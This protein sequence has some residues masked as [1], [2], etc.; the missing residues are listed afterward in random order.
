MVLIWPLLVLAM[1]PAASVWFKKSNEI[2]GN[3]VEK[4]VKDTFTNIVSKWLLSTALRQVNWCRCLLET[5]QGQDAGYCAYSENC[6]LIRS[7]L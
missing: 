6:V 4:M 3:S 7:S 2:F 1:S 5:A